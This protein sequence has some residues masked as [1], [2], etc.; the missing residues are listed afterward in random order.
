MRVCLD[1]ATM[2]ACIYRGAQP[3][4]RKPVILAKPYHIELKDF[5]S[6]EE[7]YVPFSFFVCV[8][9]V[10]LR[11]TGFFVFFFASPFSGGGD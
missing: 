6:A 3:E 1:D 2:H 5:P 7:I 8:F 11:F 9:V 10:C 4:W